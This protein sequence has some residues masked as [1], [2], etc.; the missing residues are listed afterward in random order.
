[1]TDQLSNLN[2]YSMFHLISLIW[3]ALSFSNPA[4]KP[5]QIM[6]SD[7]ELDSLHLLYNECNLK[8]VVSFSTF[9]ASMIGFEKFHPQKHIV[10][11]VDFSLPSSQKRFFIVDLNQKLLL[12][13]TWAAHGKNSGM[14]MA[15]HFSNKMQSYQSSPGF[16]LVGKQITSPKHGLALELFGLEKGRNDNAAKREIIIHG[17][18]YVSE[19]F[20]QQFGRCG[21]SH[22]CPALPIELMPKVAPILARGSL[23][24]IHVLQKG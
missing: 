18:S 20:I 6:L 12:F 24:Y 22:G 5:I 3:I 21:R 1:M 8:D 11:I 14:E 7:T 9:K 15:Q 19:K 10:S 17:A 4:K 23:L 13:S 2:T 16:Y